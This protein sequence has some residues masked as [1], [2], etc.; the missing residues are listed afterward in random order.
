MGIGQLHNTLMCITGMQVFWLGVAVCRASCLAVSRTGRCL[1]QAWPWM[2]SEYAGN[3]EYAGQQAASLGCLCLFAL[4]AGSLAVHI[5]GFVI[6]VGCWRVCRSV[7]THLQ[8]RVLGLRLRLNC[9]R[10]HCAFLPTCWC[11][12]EDGQAGSGLLWLVS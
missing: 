12:W 10:V 1:R 8:C 9:V 5:S 3:S 11:A 2:S 4:S 6:C 7:Y